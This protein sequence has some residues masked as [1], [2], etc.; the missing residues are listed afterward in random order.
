[1]RRATAKAIPLLALAAVGTFASGSASAKSAQRCD[2]HRAIRKDRVALVFSK[3]TSQDDGSGSPLTIYYACARPNGKAV[4]LAL[5]SYPGNAEYPPND[6][7]IALPLAGDYA[8][9]LVIKG[10]ADYQACLMLQPN[11]PV[12]YTH[13]ALVEV[14]GR[15]R[16]TLTG[17]YGTTALELSPAGEAAWLEPGPSGSEQKLMATVL[18]ARGPRLHVA[19]R[20]L[21]TGHISDVH[22]S[23]RRLDWRDD[24]GPRSATLSPG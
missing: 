5:D 8:G 19:P 12:P 11:C 6:D 3:A 18:E 1:M 16:A 15:R 17:P 20:L 2:R 14:R 10:L 7:L 9:S 23:G 24:Q 13:I 21:D 22:F 4:Q